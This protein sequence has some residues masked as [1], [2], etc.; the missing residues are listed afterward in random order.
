MDPSSFYVPVDMELL[1]QY[2]VSVVMD[3][4]ETNNP[5]ISMVQIRV[6][7]KNNFDRKYV[8]DLAVGA[9]LDPRSITYT[10][11][12]DVLYG[13]VVCKLRGRDG[14][15]AMSGRCGECSKK[16]GR[17]QCGAPNCANNVRFRRKFIVDD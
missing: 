6:Y 14:Y 7:L 9:G 16:V 15:W 10:P 17:V 4:I 1:S 13:G 5:D 12:A 3:E 11:G 2:S 8:Q